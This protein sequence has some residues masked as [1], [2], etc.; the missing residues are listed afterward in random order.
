MPYDNLMTPYIRKKRK[1]T[2]L[3]ILLVV[4]FLHFMKECKYLE[5]HVSEALNMQD[6]FPYPNYIVPYLRGQGLNNQLWEFRSSAY[7]AKAENRV[8][9][10]VPFHRFYMQKS[11]REFI[12]FEELF[13]VKLLKKYVQVELGEVCAR[14]CE[15]KLDYN[16]EFVSKFRTGTS[17]RKPFPIADWRPGSLQ[18]FIRSTGFEQVP[19]PRVVFLSTNISNVGLNFEPLTAINESFSTFSSERCVSVMGTIPVP[20]KEHLAW[21]RSLEVSQKIKV[22]VEE[23]KKYMFGSTS[24]LA[25]H[26]RFEETKCA[27]V[28]KGIGY[29]RSVGEIKSSRKYL[30]KKSD[31][32]ADLCFYAGLVPEG[33]KSK[34]IWL[35]LVSRN[36]VVNWIQSIMKERRIENVYLATDCHDHSILTWIK[37]KIGGKSKSDLLPIIK[38]YLPVEDNDILSRVEQQ[39][40]SEAT[41]FAGT[42][43]SSWTSSV[44]EE[45]FKHHE[46][47]FVQDKFNITKRPDPQ[48]RTFYLDIEACNCDW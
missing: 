20:H 29:G 48:N 21:T 26:W 15:G 30:V 41:I 14:S 22:A 4:V 33:S 1:R 45:R 7:I 34:G 2:T 47:I 31:K 46:S 32:D 3:Y 16:V 12:P 13:D 10:L 28:G 23:I 11:G 37:S 24:Y 35:R 44:I 38:Q 18:K 9:C 5:P 40:C 43:T 27:G 25:I 19:K 17:S 6:L 36:A 8:L 39:L 42:L